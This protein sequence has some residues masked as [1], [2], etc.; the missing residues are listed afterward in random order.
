MARNIRLCEG[1]IYC[2]LYNPRTRTAALAPSSTSIVEVMPAAGEENFAPQGLVRGR[3]PL[4]KYEGGSAL[5][6]SPKLKTQFFGQP[7]NSKLSPLRGPETQNSKLEPGAYCENGDC[8]VG[9]RARYKVYTGGADPL[10]QSHVLAH[11]RATPA[12]T[13][14]HDNVQ[15]PLGAR[16]RGDAELAIGHR[17]GVINRYRSRRQ[18]RRAQSEPVHASG[19]HFTR[20]TLAPQ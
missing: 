14:R 13:K 11:T 7:Q 2:S 17:E 18:R 9:S 19:Q 16:A 10:R 6:P 20:A 1:D 4:G 8:I 3:G 12:F 5:R 15:P